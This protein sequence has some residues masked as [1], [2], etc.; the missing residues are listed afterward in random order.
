[1][2]N[3]NVPMTREGYEKLQA[4]LV[5]MQHE[6]ADVTRRVAEAR[7]EG[8]LSE[9][10]E[11]HGAREA[12]GMLQARMNMLR[13]KLARAMIIDVSTLPRDVVRFGTK[14]KVLDMDYDDEEEFELVGPG[15]DDPDKNR[16]LTSSPIGQ[17]LMGKK[18]GDIA[19]IEVPRGK[20]KFKILEISFGDN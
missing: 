15:D 4:E 5:K 20:L 16:I 11:Y 2:V 3:D 12:Q 13:D 7:G 18:I 6:M 9:N 1:M 8:D 19:E 17:G 10:A 14:V